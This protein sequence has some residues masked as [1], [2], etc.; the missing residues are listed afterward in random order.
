MLARIK[1]LTLSSSLIV[2]G[3]STAAYAQGGIGDVAKSL[4]TDSLGPMADLLGALAFMGGVV[5]AIIGLWMLFQHQKNPHNPNSS[6]G[7][8]ITAFIV[9]AGLIGIPSYLGV[10]VATF[11]GSGAET[12]S[13]DGT[14]RSIN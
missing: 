9:A 8:A 1:R 4:Q 12:S 5:V 3:L 7:R 13:V 11:F 14:L 6:V 10:G 2:L